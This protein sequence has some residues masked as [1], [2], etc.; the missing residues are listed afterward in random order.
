MFLENGLC[1]IG[2]K[3]GRDWVDMFWGNFF[4]GLGVLSGALRV[5]DLI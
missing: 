2:R 1:Y 4:G 5:V 3:E